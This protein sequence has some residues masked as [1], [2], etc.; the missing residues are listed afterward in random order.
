MK[1]LLDNVSLFWSRYFNDYPILVSLLDGAISKIADI[2]LD[3]YANLLSIGLDACPALITRDVAKISL[4]D[5]NFITILGSSD[6]TSSGNVL[7]Y[8]LGPG[9]EFRSIPYLAISPDSDVFLECGVDFELY[10]GDSEE[11]PQYIRDRLVPSRRYLQFSID[12]RRMSPQPRYEQK[13]YSGVYSIVLEEIPDGLSSTEELKISYE[14]DTAPIRVLVSGVIPETKEVIL[15]VSTPLPSVSFVA[16]ATRSTTEETVNVVSA[17]TK[18]HSGRV[19]FL[20]A[21]NPKV[22]P[23]LLREQFG[24]LHTSVF[25]ES[26]ELY[27]NFLLGL[28]CLRNMPITKKN[29]AASVCLCS[30]V[31]VFQTSYEN[32]DRIIR[33]ERSSSG[34]SVVH[35]TLAK[36]VVPNGLS[37]RTE[38]LNDAIE[39]SVDGYITASRE[40]SHPQTFKFDLLDCIVSDVTVLEGNGDNFSWWDKSILSDSFVEIP[41]SMMPGEP[42]VRRV[43]INQVHDNLIG[44]VDITNYETTYR[45]PSPS[46]GDYS[47]EIGDSTRNTVAYN[48][49]KDFIRHHFTF[50]KIS[51]EF[52]QSTM[53]GTVPEILRDIQSTINQCS[54]PGTSI[55]IGTDLD[56]VLE[57][58]DEDYILDIIDPEV[59]A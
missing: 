12:P 56:A 28:L 17:Q 36:Y 31:P 21:L 50:V 46:I 55:L 13:Y 11:L 7:L 42:L 20:W 2:K 51:P 14:G 45:L 19:T 26:S 16:T 9:A 40:F 15:S 25:S 23:Y 54:N 27:R 4:E 58:I 41:Q 34:V 53:L 18:T 8:D 5:S 24:H 43:I 1:E 30:G 48:L 39:I 52:S 22:D 33:V 59:G 38:I 32:G 47:L 57:D 35:T 29:L 10:R 3:N 49:F 37:I 6:I 44:P